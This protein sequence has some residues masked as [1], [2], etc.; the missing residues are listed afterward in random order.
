VARSFVT[1]KASN[2]LLVYKYCSWD[3]ATRILNDLRLKVT[4]PAEFND[5]F[6][7]M[8]RMEHQL[9]Q[10]AFEDLILGETR[11]AQATAI[12]GPPPPS[13]ELIQQFT[14]ADPSL[15]HRLFSI[16]YPQTCRERVQNFCRDVS[17]GFGVVCFSLNPTNILMWSHYAEN[18][19]GVV[20][21]FQLPPHIS[22]KLIRVKYSKER[23]LFD[24][25]QP[26]GGE[27]DTEIAEK[28]ISTKHVNWEYE[29]EMRIMVKLAGLDSPRL[30]A[31]GRPLHTLP[32]AADWIRMVIV[33]MRVPAVATTDLVSKMSASLRPTIWRAMP[34]DDE[35]ELMLQEFK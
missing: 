20:I 22:D 3:S 13:L 7:F 30:S 25:A 2:A 28:I 5:P 10:A 19:K 34:H 21:G 27:Y 15:M 8:P 1:D 18:H 9:S 17:D 35:F 29:E 24:P 31:D 23:V 6:E 12:G 14:R 32:L 26:I 33:G 16:S 4:P 11:I